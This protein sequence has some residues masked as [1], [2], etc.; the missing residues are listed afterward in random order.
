[1]TKK[2]IIGK[3]G[4]P[5]GLKGYAYIHFNEYLK[6]YNFKDVQVEVIGKKYVIQDI[7]NHLSDRHLV[8]FMKID[9]VEAIEMIRSSF[10]YLNFIEIMNL[11]R[12]LPWPE[13][14]LGEEV[15]NGDQLDIHLTNYIV[16]NSHT[17]LEL[18]STNNQTY[19]IPYI[20]ENFTF[21]KNGLNLSQRLTI[22]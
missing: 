2:Y 12:D 20:N 9:S 11:T 21:N 8:K 13:L 19:M 16:Y 22:Y 4:K 6:T 3:I 15:K 14:F 7:K 5:H 18:T 10:V 1:M 17:V